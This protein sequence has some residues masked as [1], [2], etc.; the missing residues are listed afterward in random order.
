MASVEIQKRAAFLVRCSTNKQDYERQI[1]DLKSVADRFNLSVS[2]EN[3]FGEYIT[4]RDDTTKSDRLSIIKLRE[5][6]QAKKF[7]CILVAEVSR[8]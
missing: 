8:M 3:I 1:E 6:A 4:G 5:A 2:E 7:D